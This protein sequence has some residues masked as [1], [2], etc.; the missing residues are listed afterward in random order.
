[1]EGRAPGGCKP[2]QDHTQPK[3]AAKKQREQ[4]TVEVLKAFKDPT[5]QAA[6]FSALLSKMAEL[7]L[8]MPLVLPTREPVV[9]LVDSSNSQRLSHPL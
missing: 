3:A 5:I 8:A 7:K 2:P 1:M 6:Q 9:F 4:L